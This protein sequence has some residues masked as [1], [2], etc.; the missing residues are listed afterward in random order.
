MDSTLELLGYSALEVAFFGVSPLAGLL[1]K[2]RDI[3]RG[4]L[5]GV[6]SGFS[7]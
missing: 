5:F 2:G 1:V 6:V 3:S 7:E 4:E